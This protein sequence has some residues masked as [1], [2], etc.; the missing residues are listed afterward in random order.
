MPFPVPS[1]APA[2]LPLLGFGLPVSGG[3]ALPHTVAAVARRAEA[4]GWTSLWTFQRVLHPVGSDLPPTHRSVLDPVVPL[5]Y[6]AALT[7]RIG[8]GT[9]TICAPYLAPVLLAKQLASLDVLSRGRLT[10]GLGT[11][12]LPEERTAVGLAPGRV[13]AR[14]DEYLRCLQAVWTQDP[15]EH[16]GEFYT[17]PLS[18]VAPPPVQRPHPPVLVGGSSGAA[19]RRA[20]RLAQGWVVSSELDAALIAPGVEEVRRAAASA[21]RDPA[22]VRVVARR[23]VDLTGPSARGA[24]RPFR[25]TPEQVL[26]DLAALAADGV[27]EVVLDLN[28]L[29]RNGS[30]GSDP[31]AALE[32]AE[33]VLEALAP[34]A[35]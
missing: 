31:A 20:G 15:V 34:P 30:E 8:L 22:A 23:V 7:D 19:L 27:T 1:S 5:A 9:A 4:L 33:R 28:L 17:V 13:G 29:S 3:W 35:R 11:G 6:A 24:H 18:C 25:G 26:D 16:D 10:V 12:W 32:E 21:G 2:G 14:M